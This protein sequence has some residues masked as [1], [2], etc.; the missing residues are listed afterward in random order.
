M[1]FFEKEKKKIKTTALMRQERVSL[2]HNFETFTVMFSALIIES[3]CPIRAGVTEWSVS[4]SYGVQSIRTWAVR[5][6]TSHAKQLG[7]EAFLSCKT[8]R[9]ALEPTQP[10]FQW[11]LGVFSALE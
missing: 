8:S 7:Q 1:P 6:I 10:P 2:P 4:Y 9:P 5:R 11:E 3:T